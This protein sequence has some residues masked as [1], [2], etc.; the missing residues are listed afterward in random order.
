MHQKLPKEAPNTKIA[1]KDKVI[2][3]LKNNGNQ[4]KAA[5]SKPK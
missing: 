5:K 4:P 2:S 3:S 1:K